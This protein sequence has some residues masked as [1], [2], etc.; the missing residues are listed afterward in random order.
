MKLK[1]EFTIATTSQMFNPEKMEWDK[2]IINK[3]GLKVDLLQEIVT[4]GT[5]IGVLNQNISRS[6]DVEGI[7]VIA[8]TSHD[9]AAAIAAVP[10]EGEDWAYISSGTWSL[11]G[12]E[13]E[14]V[15]V[16][17]RSKLFNFTNEGGAEGTFRFQKNIVGLWLIKEC[18]KSWLKIE[19]NLE[20]ED[21][22]S[23]AKRQILFAAMI[24]P[25]YA[26][27][28]NPL[29][30]P[31]AINTFCRQTGQTAPQSIG[32]IARTIFESLALKYRMVLEQLEMISNKSFRVIHV[33]GGGSQNKLLCQFTA[34]ATG[35]KVIAG[36]VE[37]TGAG[38][39]LMQALAQGYLKDIAHLRRVVKNSFDIATYEPQDREVWNEAYNRFLKIAKQN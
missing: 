1:S 6:I 37:A 24:D 21:I 31:A 39:L 22:E 36:P 18:R 25:D 12:M 4:P 10:A 19:E 3:L 34:N 11:M 38:V 9:T 7:K 28:Y 32:A 2:D 14:K 35:K 5:V 20:Y 23:L 27:F 15:V 33:V 17:H 13:N 26:G 29:D 30:M 8:V 16:D